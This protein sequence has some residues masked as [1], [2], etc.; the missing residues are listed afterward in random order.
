MKTIE[1]RLRKLIEV[2]TENRHRDQKMFEK[3]GISPD[4]WKNF[5]FGRKAAD[6]TMIE[7]VAKTW[8][9]FAFWLTTGITDAENG[10]VNPTD[11]KVK[12]SYL[13]ALDKSEMAERH[14][15]RRELRRLSNTIFAH[16]IKKEELENRI[17]E[18][19]DENANNELHMQIGNYLFSI[20][21]NER[22]VE[23]HRLTLA[24][25][26]EKL[27]NEEL[28]NDERLTPFDY[29]MLVREVKKR[30]SS[31]DA[32][33]NYQSPTLPEID[34]DDDLDF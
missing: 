4:K 2:V 25:L 16:K 9:G 6:A 3:T 1:D 32:Y 18:T 19:N 12:D 29:K 10:H 14:F 17:A 27:I 5:W 28:V 21:E 30:K 23:L 20:E 26:H 7:L 24:K 33:K 8:P 34:S 22:L 11:Y 31:D 13:G 15:A